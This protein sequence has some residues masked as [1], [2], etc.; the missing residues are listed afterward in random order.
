MK[1][2]SRPSELLQ[3]FKMV[4][5]NFEGNLKT[6]EDGDLTVINLNQF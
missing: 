2:N 6:L 1:H 3:S 4:S 5:D